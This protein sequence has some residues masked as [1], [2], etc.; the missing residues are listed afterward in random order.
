MK[1]LQDLDPWTTVF[2]NKL[3]NALRKFD[4]SGF[5]SDAEIIL[6]I[7]GG[8]GKDVLSLVVN[9]ADNA[10]IILCDPE[11]KPVSA[12]RNRKSFL[13]INKRIEE[14]NS[15]DK[16]IFEGKKIIVEMSHVLQLLSRTDQL[17]ILRKIKEIVGHGGRA[18]IVDEIKRPGWSGIYDLFLN[19]FFN[20]FEGNYNRQTSLFAFEQLVEDSGFRILAKKQY[21]RGSVLFLLE[22]I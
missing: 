3:V 6:S 17:I 7:G 10:E 19:R 4:I 12:L 5:F 16:S 22:A 20:R 15:E 21:Y 1:N 18:I 14:L 8:N 2:A 13:C 9:F 11:A